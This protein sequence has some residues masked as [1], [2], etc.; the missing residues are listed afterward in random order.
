MNDRKTVGRKTC[1]GIIPPIITSFDKYGNVYERGC[2]NVIDFQLPYVDGFYI[3]GSYGSGPLM[4]VDERK[5]VLEIMAEQVNG[6]ATV[7]AHVGGISTQS[8]IELAKHAEVTGVDAI[9]VVPPY[10]YIHSEDNLLNHY[11]AVLDAVNIPVYAYDNPKLSNDS[12]TS[13]ILSKLSKMGAA[14][15]KDSSFSIINLIE[16]MY[17]IE[18]TEFSYIIGTEALLVPA[19]IM[20]AQA[21]IS[22]LANAL[23]IIMFELNKAFIEKDFNKARELQLKVNKARSILHW[24]PTIASVHTILDYKGIDAGFPR[25]PFRKIDKTKSQEI[26]NALKQLGVLK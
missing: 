24:A 16:K 12:I 5:K 19:F 4:D 13:S 18:D 15:L 20:G 2:R 26:I 9:G 7:I 11:K 23:P 17:S 14:G 8:T 1:H 21:C 25:S 10:Y 6:K 3:C 22:G